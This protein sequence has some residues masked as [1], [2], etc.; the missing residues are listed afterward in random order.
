MSLLLDALKKAAEQKAE[1]SRSD[2]TQVEESDETIVVSPAE[3][4][5]ELENPDIK[6]RQSQAGSEDETVFDQTEM[7][8][9]TGYDATEM[10]DLT[11]VEATEVQTRIDAASEQMQTGE[12]ETIVFA[13]EDVSDFMG[14]PQ[15]VSREREDETELVPVEPDVT[16]VSQLTQADVTQADV[17]QA[18]VTQYEGVTTGADD[19]DMSQPF[20]PGDQVPEDQTDFTAQVGAGDETEFT[21]QVAAADET[22]AAK[23]RPMRLA[24]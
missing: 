20:R 2:I 22:E 12:D 17:T 3:D 24:T 13:T 14:E 21:E 4:I 15:L 8:D 10:Q 1:K 5:S 19:T 18:D 9:H 23:P 16:D 7:Q 6:L 11:D